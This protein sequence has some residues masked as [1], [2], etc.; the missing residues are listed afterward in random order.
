MY[1]ATDL[2]TRDVYRFRTLD[3]LARRLA[4]PRGDYWVVHESTVRPPTRRIEIIKPQPKFGWHI[5]TTVSVP[6]EAV[7]A[8]GDESAPTSR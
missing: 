4:G 1:E 3:T 2:S 7:E 5:V 8:A 6:T